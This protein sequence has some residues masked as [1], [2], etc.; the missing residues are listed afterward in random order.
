[1]VVATERHEVLVIVHSQP[2]SVSIALDEVLKR[3]REIRKYFP[4]L[5]ISS[6]IGTMTFDVVRYQAI[7]VWQLL[8]ANLTQHASPPEAGFIEF[9]HGTFIRT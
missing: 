3:M 2:P 9:P 5:I 6:E 1:V 4:D 7:Y 8:A